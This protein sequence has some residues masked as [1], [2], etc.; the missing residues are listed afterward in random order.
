MAV[1]LNKKLTLEEILEMAV[2]YDPAYVSEGSLKKIIERNPQMR[3]QFN[4]QITEEFSAEVRRRGI[5]YI[6]NNDSWK[7]VGGM[8]KTLRLGHVGMDEY[9][10]ISFNI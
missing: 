7:W 8:K 10:K 5:Y 3:D 2:P 4:E 1:N 6:I 9:P